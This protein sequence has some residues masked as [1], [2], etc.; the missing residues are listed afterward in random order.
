MHYEYI[1]MMRSLM[2]NDRV[3]VQR[4]LVSGFSANSYDD[5]G[6]TMLYIAAFHGR[7]KVVE[8]LV[9]F[10]ADVHAANAEGE[11]PVQVALRTQQTTTWRMINVA[12]ARY[13]AKHNKPKE[14]HTHS[15]MSDERGGAV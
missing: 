8:P 1:K 2:M 11:T 6:R 5:T 13:G 9:Q 12:Y 10:G 3:G 4:V 15:I 7:E 14:V